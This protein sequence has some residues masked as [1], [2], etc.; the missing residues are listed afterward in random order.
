[1]MGTAAPLLGW[2]HP[3][4]SVSMAEGLRSRGKWRNL[5]Q[6]PLWGKMLYNSP[7]DGSWCPSEGTPVGSELG[8]PGAPGFRGHPPSLCRTSRAWQIPRH[9]DVVMVTVISCNSTD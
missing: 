5:L 9:R 2:G 8:V 6:S 4:E 7:G 1:M 3:G